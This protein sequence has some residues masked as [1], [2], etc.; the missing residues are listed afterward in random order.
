MAPDAPPLRYGAPGCSAFRDSER[1]S[2]SDDFPLE[3]ARVLPALKSLTLYTCPAGQGSA[4]DGSLCR[5]AASAAHRFT[6]GIRIYRVAAS[7]SSMAAETTPG[8]SLGRKCPAPATTR[9][10]T[11]EVNT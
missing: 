11:S 10:A 9:R 3:G 5:Q 7:T 1:Q 8:F 4:G 2:R 6:L